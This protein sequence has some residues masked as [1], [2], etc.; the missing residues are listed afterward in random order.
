MMN[1]YSLNTSLSRPSTVWTKFLLALCIPI[2]FGMFFTSCKKDSDVGLGVQPEEDIIGLY[3]TDTLTLNTFTVIE[4]S[5][6]TDESPTAVIGRCEDPFFGTSV[7]GV[8]SQFSIPNNLQNLTFGCDQGAGVLDSCVLMLAYEFD[9]YGDTTQQQTFSVYQMTESIYKDSLYYSNQDKSVFGFPNLPIGTATFFPKPRTGVPVGGDSVAPHVRISIDMT[10]ANTVFAQGGG[11]NLANNTNWLEYMNGLYITPTG[12]GSKSLLQFN[13]IDTSTGLRFYYHNPCDTAEF[14]FSVT[15]GS[16]FYCRYSHDY[17]T[18]TDITNA[19]NNPTIPSPVCFIQ[20]NAGLKTKVEFPTLKNWYDNLGYPAAINKAELV[21]FGIDDQNDPT[22]FPLNTRMFVTS[23]D[24]VN[25][26][27]LIIDMFES[28]TYFGGSLN[29]TNNCYKINIA[30]YIQS[31][32]TGGKDDNGLFLKEIF[33]T[34]NGRR[35]TIGSSH[36]VADPT[37]RMYLHLV[38]TRIN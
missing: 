22:N 11:T 26:E 3:A 17:S 37:K 20:S 32:L 30:R 18:A 29:T 19:L 25:K 36:S 4:D 21:I 2:V 15:T 16:A 33:G 7:C 8:Y 23:I 34:E 14:T 6:R 10:W 13:M 35:S 1:K 5:L 24:S 31:V 38:Y 28:S 9:Y 27:H 12:T